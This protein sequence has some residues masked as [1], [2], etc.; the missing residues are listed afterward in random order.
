M[1][2]QHE[3]PVGA[4]AN[5]GAAHTVS[6]TPANT[7]DISQLPYLLREDGRAVF[8]DKVY[9]NNARALCA[10]TLGGW[11]ARSRAARR[12]RSSGPTIASSTRYRRSERG[13]SAFSR[14]QASIWLHQGARC[15]WIVKNAAQV[16]S[17]IL[18]TNLCLARRA[19]IS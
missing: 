2:L 14:D 16:L 11:G 15:K 1:V 7:P 9:V 17:L 8:G 13:W 3:D 18:L 19:W 4:D 5:S 10:Q 6:V 12:H